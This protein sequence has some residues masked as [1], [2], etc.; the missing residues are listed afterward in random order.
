MSRILILL[1]AFLIW[2]NG[3]STFAQD[4]KQSGVATTQAKPETEKPKTEV[5]QLLEKAKERGELVVARCLENCGENVVEGNVEA[6]RAL[7]LPKPGYPPL[8]RAARASGQVVVQL[9]VDVDGTV[10]A[11]AAV[12]GHPL[13]YGVSV[14]AAKNSRFEPTKLDGK[15]VK[16]T[17]VITYNFVSQ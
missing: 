2:S 17:G 4:N 12:S 9:I 10:M 3:S 8:A 16:V 5:D 15:P 6:G 14:E 1:S 7:E 11:A 13:L